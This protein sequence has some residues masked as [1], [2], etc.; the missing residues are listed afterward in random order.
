M[1]GFMASVDARTQ[2]AG[3]NRME[4]LL[5]RLRG[6]QLFGINV[7][8]VRE[9]IQCPPLTRVPQSHPDVRGIISMRGNTM[10]V[11]DLGRA[12]GLSPITDV[13][14]SFLVVTEYNGSVQGFLVAAVDRIVNHNWADI[15]PPP[16]GATGGHY[17]TAVAHIDEQ[18]VE[19]IDVERVLAEVVGAP[20]EVSEDIGR[21]P[22]DEGH[23]LVLIVDDSA[24]ARKQMVK[25]L[26]QVGCETI[27]AKDG[28]EAFELLQNWLHNDTEE[29]KRLALVV[30][31]IE[32]PRMDG[33][34]LTSSIRQ[35]DGLKHFSVILHTS[36]SGGF[37]QAMV[38]K[39]GAD[40]FISKF[41]AD[42][43]AQAVLEH[44]NK[45]HDPHA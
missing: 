7:F 30:S 14:G 11:L 32:M 2:L 25:T 27:T 34:T 28:A 24:V 8:K 10:S 4:L 17:L 40:K 41:E 37:N 39:V 20:A 3:R 21:D 31:D 23:N 18:L 43:F 9:V 38:D 1:A 15:L 36:L 42:L 35:T 26:G 13:D 19:I 6:K 16:Q 5:F 12:I 22:Q 45:R 29:M 33:Y 44:L